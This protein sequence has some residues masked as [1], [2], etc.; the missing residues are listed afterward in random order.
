MR[1]EY[2][3]PR[4]IN[5]ETGGEEDRFRQQVREALDLD[6]ST[7]DYKIFEELRRLKDVDRRV[8][9]LANSTD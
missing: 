7:R 1:K 8:V 9:A 2:R 5:P 6:W 3:E 4:S